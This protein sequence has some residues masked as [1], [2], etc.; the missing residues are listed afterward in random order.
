MNQAF[1]H[2]NK[3]RHAAALG[4]TLVLHIALYYGWRV[5]TSIA[6]A[7][8]GEARS[9]VSSGCW[10][11]RPNWMRGGQTWKT[12]RGTSTGPPAGHDAAQPSNPGD[13]GSAACRSL[14]RS[15]VLAGCGYAITRGTRQEQR[16]RDR[17]GAAQGEPEQVNQGAGRH[18][19]H[20]HAARHPGSATSLAPNRWYQAPKVTEM[21]DPG[22][23]R[24]E[25]LPRRWR[26]WDVLRDRTRR[27]THRTASTAC[28]TG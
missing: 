23:E 9:S 27:I 2:P 8:Y 15:A 25:T 26:K 10:C 11:P 22:R 28:S 14:C 20:A 24:T 19:P 16:R 1:P 3:S 21:V 5:G 13:H 7:R 6:S 18:R 4:L 17:Q 12:R